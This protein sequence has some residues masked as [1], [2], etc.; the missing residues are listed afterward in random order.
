ME[1]APP[2]RGVERAAGSEE[3]ESAEAALAEEFL[4]SGESAGSEAAE[5]EALTKAGRVEAGHLEMIGAARAGSSFTEPSAGNP[6]GLFRKRFALDQLRKE[7]TPI[8]KNIM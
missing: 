3:A 2:G 4:E 1:I 8:S 7:P 6:R 5:A